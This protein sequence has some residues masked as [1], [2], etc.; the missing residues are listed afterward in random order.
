MSVGPPLTDHVMP[1]DDDWLRNLADAELAVAD[2]DH[3]LVAARI[4][5]ASVV[6]LPE[7]KIDSILDKLRAAAA[8]AELG[9]GDAALRSS[10]ALAERSCQ[11]WP[12]AVKLQGELARILLALARTAAPEEAASLRAR[13]AAI[14][15]PLEARGALA[16]KLRAELGLRKSE[17]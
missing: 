12:S 10:L 3:D 2:A 15:A 9:G 8:V 14:I 6:A 7:D 1:G 5:L 17:R 13:A 11:R 4:A 16:A